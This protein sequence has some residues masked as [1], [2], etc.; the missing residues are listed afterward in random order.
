[1]A[2]Q[3]G[4][5]RWK[6]LLQPFPV[7]GVWGSAFLTIVFL[8]PSAILLHPWDRGSILAVLWLCLPWSPA[9]SGHS[10]LAVFVLC[11]FSGEC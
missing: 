1:M 3:R 6:S 2:P 11:G 4:A 9:C 5:V 7:A 8:H 10:V